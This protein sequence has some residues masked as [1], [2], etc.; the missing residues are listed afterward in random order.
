MLFPEVHVIAEVGIVE[1]GR[2]VQCVKHDLR[3]G[4]DDQPPAVRWRVL[5]M[6]RVFAERQQPHRVRRL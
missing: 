6:E 5:D 3:D 4:T 2:D 1:L